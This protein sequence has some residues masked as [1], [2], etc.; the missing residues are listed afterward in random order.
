MPFFDTNVA[1]G[2]PP[3]SGFRVG[4]ANLDDNSPVE[5]GILFPR[6]SDPQATYVYYECT[7]G[8]VLDSGVVVHNRLPQVES[9]VV[10]TLAVVGIDDPSLDR[11]YGF[12]V[13]LRCL[14]QYQDVIQR[15]AH[16]RYWFR[17]WGQALRIGYQVPIPGIRTIGG[18]PAIPH[19][20]NPQWAYNSIVPGG[21]YSGAILWRAAWSLWYTTAVPPSTFLGS[22]T[23]I[24]SPDAAAH[25]SGSRF[26]GP[27]ATEQSPYSQADDNARRSRG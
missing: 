22:R 11:V 8:M 17:L 18:V 9:S 10:D 16:S 4:R 15:M 26:S 25:I 14:D 19:D 12:G 1:E 23:G 20:K 5:Q 6:P 2:L 24:I 21:N 7:V 27:P 13:N 3:N